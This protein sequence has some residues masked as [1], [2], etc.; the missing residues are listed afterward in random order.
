MYE[1]KRKQAINFSIT[2]LSIMF[3][4]SIIVIFNGCAKPTETDKA[5]IECREGHLYSI[6]PTKRYEL[7]EKDG[8]TG[9]KVTLKR[10]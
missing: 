10:G 5:Y 2:I 6:I 9:G 7:I 3:A 4:V 8:C 1:E